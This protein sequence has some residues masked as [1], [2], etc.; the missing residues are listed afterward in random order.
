L[1]CA[2]LIALLVIVSLTFR[3]YAI[4]ND[5]E[6]QQRYG[7]LIIAYYT[8]GFADRSVFGFKNLYLYGGLF[9]VASTLLARM[10]PFDVYLIR[11]VLS[12][13]TG[14]GGVAAAAA[15][16]RLIAGPRAGFLAAAMLS[17]CGI[18]YGA[19]FNHTK[20]IPFAAAMMGA[21]YFLL[22][23]AR[24]LPRPRC[25]D[26]IGFGVLLG[27]VLGLRA[28]GLLLPAYLGLVVL[29]Q[30]LRQD[31]TWA[32]RGRFVAWS[33]IGFAPALALGYLIMIAAWPWASLAPLNPLRA[34]W[35]FAHFHYEIHTVL[36]GKVYLMDAVPRWY[37][38]AYLMIKL[39]LLL[40]AGVLL[41]AA[42][43][44]SPRL[45]PARGARLWGDA[46]G[47]MIF[48]AVFPVAA[49]AALHGPAF[50]GMRHYL[51]V[52]SAL[53]VLAGIGFDRAVAALQ[54]CGRVPAFAGL[55]AVCL[56]LAWHGAGLVRLHPYQYVFFNG[57][58]GGLEGASR[59]Y[60]VDYWV[61]IM[62]EAVD[63]LGA[64]LRGAGGAGARYTVGVCGERI[65]F[66]HAAG[67]G[68][69]WTG[70]WLQADFFIAPTNM[71]CDRVLSGRIAFTIER[72][73]VAI[74][75]VQDLRGLAPH[76]RGFIDFPGGVAPTYAGPP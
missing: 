7:E 48:V 57:L 45:V 59:R 27:A 12:A 52:V 71:N 63:R 18:W 2:L 62:P 64:Y 68:L 75:V 58:V 43:W 3:D 4:S 15:T 60:A 61:N 10:L 17:V 38:P 36:A 42:A 32:G 56:L 34:V 33:M 22:R 53:A 73:G 44:A 28:M 39:P 5:E 19:M 70:D 24:G 74:G 30:A 29:V 13:L 16:A 76:A 6:V 49:A 14:I 51:F 66:E 25:R 20:D 23:G 47:L 9:D 67:A 69:Q 26:V 65:S 31:A 55:A 11:H 1:T 8:S 21:I 46:V 37:V 54:R 40:F 50:T 41:A 35:T 72:E